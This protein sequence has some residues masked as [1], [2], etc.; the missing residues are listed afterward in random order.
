MG[1]GRPREYDADQ[2]LAAAGQVFWTKGF[3]ATSLD[4][5]SAAMA[6]NRPSIYRAFGDKKAVYRQALMLFCQAMEDAFA[7]TM[8]AEGDIRR[9]LT[10][11]YSEAVETYTG[12]GMARGCM[13]MS[14]AVAAAP[15]HPEIQSDLLNIIRDLDRKMAARLQQ[16]VADGQ[17]PASFDVDERA[18]IAQS[19]LHSLSLRARAGESRARLRR[20][21]RAGVDMLLS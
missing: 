11:F 8:L 6:M 15:C 1:R 5:L 9:A 2:A 16:A 18:A 21:I 7:R 10:R 4:D 12:G 14:T 19:L 17:L 3:S 13:V 20:M